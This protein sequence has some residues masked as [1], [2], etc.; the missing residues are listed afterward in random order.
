MSGEIKVIKT[1][2]QSGI[3]IREKVKVAEIGPAVGRLYGEV[4]GYMA[5]NGLRMTTAPFLYYH[6]CVD[7]E[8]DMEAGFPCASKIKNDGRFHTF[9]LPSLKAVHMTYVGPY[10]TLMSAYEKM[11]AFMKE[12]GL[13]P[14]EQMWEVYISDPDET[15]PADLVTELYWPVD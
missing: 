14:A 6:S 12:K 8:V 10:N 2:E 15:A 9:T 3:A 5:R 13:K 7:G 4:A 1:K 11:E